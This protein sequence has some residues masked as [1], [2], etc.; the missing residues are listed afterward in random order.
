MV[1][2]CDVNDCGKMG[3]YLP[4][5]LV[6]KW[7]GFLISGRL[8]WTDG[9]G[10]I[11]EFGFCKRFAVK[12]GSWGLLFGEGVFG[13]WECECLRSDFAVSLKKNYLT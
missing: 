3:F 2:G 8:C 4:I 7:V 10:G 5:Y 1:F 12:F 13:W 6:G 9:S 11:F